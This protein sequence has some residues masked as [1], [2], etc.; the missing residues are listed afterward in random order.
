M[1]VRMHATVSPVLPRELSLP[2]PQFADTA[3][4]TGMTQSARALGYQQHNQHHRSAQAR[5]VTEQELEEAAQQLTDALSYVNKGIQFRI[6]DRTERLMVHIIDRAT[7]EVIKEIPP[8]EFLDVVANIQEYMG[9]L[10][11]KR[12]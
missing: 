4:S 6:H 10:F 7:Q 9:L 1:S 3:R 2:A 11:D 8:E 5:S 12:V